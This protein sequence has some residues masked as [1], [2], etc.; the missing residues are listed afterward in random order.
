MTFLYPN[1]KYCSAMG[2]YWKTVLVVEI[3]I[4]LRLLKRLNFWSDYKIAGL[5]S[6]YTKVIGGEWNILISR[7]KGLISTTL[8]SD[9][10]TLGLF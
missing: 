2:L 5:I 4:S 3:M 10:N 7:A 9:W 8:L 6:F 1:E